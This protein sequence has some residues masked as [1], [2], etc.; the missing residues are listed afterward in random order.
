MRLDSLDGVSTGWRRSQRSPGIEN[1]SLDSSRPRAQMGQPCSVLRWVPCAQ[2]RLFVEKTPKCPS[3]TQAMEVRRL[4]DIL[5]REDED[6]NQAGDAG[7]EVKALLFRAQ[8]PASGW[9][10]CGGRGEWSR[11]PGLWLG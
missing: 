10:G 8:P 9:N 5:E 3:V 4:P 2:H 6:G 1:S 7:D 11:A